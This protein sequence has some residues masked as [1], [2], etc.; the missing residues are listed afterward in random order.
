MPFLQEAWLQ[1]AARVF[2][3]RAFAMVCD[4]RGPYPT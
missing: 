3:G 2:T 1:K 4:L